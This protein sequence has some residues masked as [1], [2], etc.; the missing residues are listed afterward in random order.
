MAV[1]R[2]VASLRSHPE[3]IVRSVETALGSRRTYMRARV[4]WRWHATVPFALTRVLFF[5]NAPQISA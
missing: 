3:D 1:A 4:A 2:A 5:L